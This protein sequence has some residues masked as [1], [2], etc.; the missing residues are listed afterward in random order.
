M[1]SALVTVL[2]EHLVLIQEV[3]YVWSLTRFL[4]NS[5]NQIISTA[6]S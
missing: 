1:M 3:L 6:V 5:V 2:L 4:K